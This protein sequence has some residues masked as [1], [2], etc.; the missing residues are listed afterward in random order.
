MT[1]AVPL[2]AEGV[3]AAAAKL[4]PQRWQM[5]SPVWAGSPQ[6]GQSLRGGRDTNQMIRRMTNPM[7]QIP[8]QNVPLTTPMVRWEITYAMITVNMTIAQVDFRQR[9][10]GALLRGGTLVGV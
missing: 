6:M 5:V 1:P 2:S 7:N 10:N 9:R 3:L 4:K 8:I